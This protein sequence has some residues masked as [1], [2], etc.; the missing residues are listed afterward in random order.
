VH[1]ERTEL[2]EDWRMDIGLIGLGKM[3]ANMAE[4]LVRGGHR[5]VAFDRSPEAVAASVAR[6]SEGAA[7]LEDLVAKLGAPGSGPRIAWVMVPAGDP[8]QMTI[9]ALA[10]LMVPGD[11]VIDGGNSNYKQT[12]ARAAALEAKQI[13]MLDAGTSGGIWGL[14]NGYCLMIGGPTSGYDHCKPIFTTLAPENGEL[15][16]DSKAGAGHF[17]KMVHNGIEYAMMQSYGE[18]LEIIEKSPFDVDQAKLTAVWNNGSVVRSW[19]LE[20]LADFLAKDPE[21]S[22]LKAYVD[23]SGEGRW[24]VDAAVEF[25]APAYTIAS[26]LFARFGSRETDAYGLKVLSALRVSFGGHPVKKAE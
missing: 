15:H 25:G 12:Q 6:G 23:D 11:I 24:T 17:T 10:A 1:P 2:G 21:L 9:D 22:T 26:A 7:S 13:T 19:L 4:R 5:V 8:T 20:L 18:G 14:E 3:G 16:V